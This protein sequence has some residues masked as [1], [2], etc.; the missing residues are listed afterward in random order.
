MAAIC[1]MVRYTVIFTGR[2]Q[3][4]YFRATACE[5]A[6]NFD[7]TGSVRNEPDGSVRLIAEGEQATL[8]AFLDAINDAKCANI[9]RV[10]VSREQ[11]IGTFSDFQITR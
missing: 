8:D 6:R 1:F 5:I 3:G 4:V 7:V 9:D 11:A 2:V 10:E